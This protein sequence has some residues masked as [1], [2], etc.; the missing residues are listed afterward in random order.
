MFNPALAARHFRPTITGPDFAVIRSTR[1]ASPAGPSAAGAPVDPARFDRIRDLG[2]LI[3]L[4]PHELA[5]DTPEG[6]NRIVQKLRRALREERQRGLAG[7]WAYNLTRHAA[8]L[9][10]YRREVAR[11]GEQ[12][13]G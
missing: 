12:G 5:D 7:H 9:R 6:C 2:G 10:A 4:W 8:L 11:V 3:P 1:A 13:V